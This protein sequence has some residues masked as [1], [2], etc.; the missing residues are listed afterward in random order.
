MKD[1]LLTLLGFA[2][3]AGKL[4]YGMNACVA[5]ILTS[6]AKLLVI[7]SDISSKSRKE[8]NFHADKKNIPVIFLQEIDIQTLSNAVGRKCGII[9]VND[10]SFA[11]GLAKANNTG[12][13]ANE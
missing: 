3:K 8:I 5:S 12:G 7:A 11:E 13:N 6:K 10:S 2:A 9:S 4:C 1:K